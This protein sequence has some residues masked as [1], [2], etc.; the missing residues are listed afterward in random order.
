M[1]VVISKAFAI[2]QCFDQGHRVLTL[3]ELARRTSMP[4]P[5]VHRLVGVLIDL[6]VLEKTDHG[7][8]LGMRLFELGG[9][10]AP[11]HSIREAARPYLS[12]LH[13]STHHVV[14]LGILD[15]GEVLYLEKINGH[16][17]V[18]APSRVAG[19]MPAHC[20]A[21]GKALLA[22]APPQVLGA[23]LES[24]MPALT[25]HTITLPRLLLDQLTIVRKTGIAVDSEESAL[26][27]YCV[28]SPVMDRDGNAVAAVSLS[29]RKVAIDPARV[30]AA[31]RMTAMGV[32][33]VIA[34]KGV[35]KI[36]NGHLA[37]T[38][39]RGSD[40]MRRFGSLA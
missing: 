21:I 18:K 40:R 25:P 36:A 10:V 29:A 17:S 32:S 26:G 3:A 39:P 2:L 6:R 15:E 19:R 23:I 20:T 37:P 7:Y 34:A 22:F 8:R 14:H 1:A 38:G 27:L 16:R 28:A 31:V 5:T 12:D 35:T 24:P 4:K 30:G 13:E 9:L 33:R 11:P